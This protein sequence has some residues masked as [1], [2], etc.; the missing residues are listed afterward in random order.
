MCVTSASLPWLKSCQV[1]H[2]SVHFIFTYSSWCISWS[3]I[4]WNPS[5]FPFLMTWSMKTTL[6]GEIHMLKTDIKT[7]NWNSRWRALSLVAQM[8]KHLT[9]MW[10]TQD[11]FQGWE[12]PLEMQMSIHSSSLAWKIPWT[13]EPGSLQS[14][15]SQSQT[16]L[17]DFTFFQGVDRNSQSL[18]CRKNLQVLKKKIWGVIS[19]FFSLSVMFLKVFWNFGRSL[20]KSQEIFEI[21]QHLRFLSLLHLNTIYW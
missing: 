20:E 15:G 14:M 5:L 21:A 7:Y 17:S 12:D 8:I 13:E 19:P 3:F 1:P 11:W 16:R 10:E 9:A 4:I 18:S 2:L 6:P